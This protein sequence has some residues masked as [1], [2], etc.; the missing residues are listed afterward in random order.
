M[1]PLVRTCFAG[2][3]LCLAL[4]ALAGCGTPA[5]VA[6]AAGPTIGEQREA[7]LF[8]SQAEREAGFRN[9]HALFPS[10]V[11]AAGAQVRPLP[12]GA[13]LALDAG[14]LDDYMGRHHIA[15]LMVLHDGN[16]RLERYGL[17]F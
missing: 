13:P 7:T 10:D 11:A 5:R 1:H 4:L 2:T 6:P 3:L 8:W 17:G 12:E 14:M 16:V 15:G 9:M